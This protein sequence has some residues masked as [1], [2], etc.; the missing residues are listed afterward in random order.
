MKN[1]TIL[2]KDKIE[3]NGN[4]ITCGVV[5]GTFYNDG[6]KVIRYMSETL[7]VAFP[8]MNDY[9]ISPYFERGPSGWYKCYM[10]HKNAP[11]ELLQKIW[12]W[13]WNEIEILSEDEYFTGIEHSIKEKFLDKWRKKDIC[14]KIKAFVPTEE[15]PYLVVDELVP[16][17]AGRYMFA[18]LL[19]MAGIDT[20]CDI[21]EYE[22]W[23]EYMDIWFSIISDT[24]GILGCTV[25]FE[26]GFG[27]ALIYCP[28]DKDQ[29]PVPPENSGELYSEYTRANI[30]DLIKKDKSRLFAEVESVIRAKRAIDNFNFGKASVEDYLISRVLLSSYIM[31]TLDSYLSPADVV[32]IQ[33]Y[34]QTKL[35]KTESGIYELITD[36]N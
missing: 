19:K 20:P 4:G 8:D 28:E 16:D 15:I 23:H 2:Y 30:T 10:E 26:E 33:D 6:N 22:H 25:N 21:D 35:H 1:F 7:Q 27:I 32:E 5:K 17:S 9:K 34:L 14:A 18:E 13:T 31:N 3:M 29:K 36:D 24:V 12:G 11:D